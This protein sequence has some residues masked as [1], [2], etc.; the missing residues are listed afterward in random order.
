LIA[1]DRRETL[2]EKCSR[3]SLRRLLLYAGFQQMQPALE[4]AMLLFRTAI[5]L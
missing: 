1:A 3:R 5:A 2:E 4:A